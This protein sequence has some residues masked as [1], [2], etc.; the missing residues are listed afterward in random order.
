MLA[1]E[2]LEFMPKDEFMDDMASEA[3]SMESTK[4]ATS[5]KAVLELI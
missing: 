3:D 1:S 5:N 2:M 4:T